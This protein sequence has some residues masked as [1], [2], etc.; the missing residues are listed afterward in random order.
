MKPVAPEEFRLTL[1][2][3]KS[4]LDAFLKHLIQMLIIPWA[5]AHYIVPNGRVFH[6]KVDKN[7]SPLFANHFMDGSIKRGAIRTEIAHFPVQAFDEF[8]T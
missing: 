4:A 5:R 7:I 8:A 6:A 2:T 1:K 3:V